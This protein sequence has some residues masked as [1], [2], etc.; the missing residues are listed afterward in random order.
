[1]LSFLIVC[2][3]YF[4]IFVCFGSYFCQTGAKLRKETQYLS[5]SLLYLYEI[6]YLLLFLFETAGVFFYLLLFHVAFLTTEKSPGQKIRMK[7]Q[8]IVVGSF[9]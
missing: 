4:F 7:N 9:F 3:R 2:V 6:V 1:M 8:I 5:F